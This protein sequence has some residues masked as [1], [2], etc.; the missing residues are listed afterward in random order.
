MPRS[1]DSKAE[2]SHGKKLL[3]NIAAGA[4][5]QTVTA[6]AALWAV[7]QI[8]ETI[9][10]AGYG[11][12]ALAGALV[13]YFSVADL[14]LANASLQ[15]LGRARAENDAAAFNKTVATSTALLGT[16]GV[17]LGIA[18]ALGA[19]PLARMLVGAEAT[20]SQLSSMVTVTRLCAIG[21]LPTMVRPILES[22]FAVSERLVI[23]YSISTVANLT[24]TIGAVIA[25]WTYP[26]TITPVA[27]LVGSSMLQCLVLLVMATISTKELRLA[28]IRASWEELKILLRISI[29]VW[30]TTATSIVANQFDKFIVSAMCGL[31]AAGRYAVAYELASRLW[32]FP[33]IF[34]R[35]YF[36]RLSNG[37]ANSEP[38]HHE[39]DI[40]SFGN[41]SFASAVVP[42][43]ALGLFAR[44]LLQAYMGVLD[45]AE[46]PTVF[47]LLLA[48]VASNVAS[49][50]A[51][52]VLQLKLH[53]KAL[54]LPY[55]AF[56]VVHGIG[57]LVLTKFWGPIGA[58]VSWSA[59]IL[60][61]GVALIVG[62]KRHYRLKVNGD[63]IRIAAGGGLSAAVLF[64]YTSTRVAPS[65]SLSSG[66]LRRLLP[67][68]SMSGLAAVA[69]VAIMG[70]V[71]FLGRQ[72][73]RA[74]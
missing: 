2:G 1:E 21:A 22:I 35:V 24:R 46:T 53:L 61:L 48:G 9:G 25:L 74:R 29:P 68:L 50:P 69:T 12:Y 18:L 58:A 41:A 67:V 70:I 36:A 38:A 63:L 37:L 10:V 45:I 66:T 26:S 47:I 43:V 23:T 32:M 59:S 34:G 55:V 56:L 57:C 42:A 60:L 19:E 11:V 31:A 65:I 62:L 7:P 3:A 52:V 54:T 8:L 27:V 17:I 15:R 49:L 40:R 20:R 30:L 72:P 16:I 64:A 4:G 51:F 73:S 5:A 6:L 71:F 28:P 14:G 39:H 13:G 33:Y 44:P